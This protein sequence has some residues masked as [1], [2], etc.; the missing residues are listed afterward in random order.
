MEEKKTVSFEDFKKD[1]KKKELKDRLIQLKD[2]AIEQG[3]RIVKGLIEHPERAIALMSAAGL[4]AG[5]VNK[6]HQ[7]NAEDRRRKRDFYDPRTGRWC[8]ARRDLTPKEEA[9]IER[10]YKL[11]KESYREILYSMHILK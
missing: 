3:E 11:N 2:K 10:R 4:L 1:A 7:T 6:I 5:K 9:E 8:T